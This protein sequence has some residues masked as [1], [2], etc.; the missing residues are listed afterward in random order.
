MAVYIRVIYLGCLADNVG[1]PQTIPQTGM[2]QCL[3]IYIVWQCRKG[4]NVLGVPLS[5]M[6]QRRSAG[7]NRGQRQAT[8][9]Q[10]QRARRL[11]G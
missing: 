9:M 6:G 3:P 7:F 5:A 11:C 4:S 10:A 1:A 2:V 8:G